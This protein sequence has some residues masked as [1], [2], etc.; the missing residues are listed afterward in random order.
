MAKGVLWPN[1]MPNRHVTRSDILK[2]KGRGQ[3]MLAPAHDR[4]RRTA[5]C[6]GTERFTIS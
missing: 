2:K 3:T 6:G 1:P 5:K 4:I